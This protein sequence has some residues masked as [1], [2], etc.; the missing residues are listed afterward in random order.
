MRSSSAIDDGGGDGDVVED[1][2]EPSMFVERPPAPPSS[3][4]WPDDVQAAFLATNL[5]L[6]YLNVARL[7]SMPIDE[8][9][10]P[11]PVTTTDDRDRNDNE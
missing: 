8:P 10:S 3:D 11:L 7:S 4:H 2:F 5:L 6:F 9:T 1:N